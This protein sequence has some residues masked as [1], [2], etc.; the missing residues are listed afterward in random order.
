MATGMEHMMKALGL[1]PEK[2]MKF[3]TEAR[4]TIQKAQREIDSRLERIEATAN[5][6]QKYLQEMVAWKRQ[7]QALALNQQS[8]PP[9][10]QPLPNPHQPTAPENR[11]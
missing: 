8:Q 11:L 7:Q 6:N 1:D 3:V 5:L 10:A 2:L 4:D 9:T